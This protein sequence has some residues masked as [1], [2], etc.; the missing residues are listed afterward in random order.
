[1]GS[2]QLDEGIGDTLVSVNATPGVG[3]FTSVFSRLASRTEAAT[4]TDPQSR[5]VDPGKASIDS[6]SSTQSSA[7][8]LACSGPNNSVTALMKAP[9]SRSAMTIR[10]A[11][12]GLSL[13]FSP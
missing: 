10:P 13:F 12:A 4:V 7:A 9:N 2:K 5:P 8:S 1:L 11:L 3:R 6:S